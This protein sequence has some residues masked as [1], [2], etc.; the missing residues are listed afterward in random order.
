MHI[1]WPKWLGFGCLL[2]A[3]FLP[4]ISEGLTYSHGLCQTPMVFSCAPSCSA[5]SWDDKRSA[6]LH[7]NSCAVWRS[8][9]REQASKRTLSDVEA[10]GSDEDVAITRRKIRQRKKKQ[11]TT[12]DPVETSSSVSGSL[13]GNHPTQV[14]MAQ[15]FVSI[16]LSVIKFS[17]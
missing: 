6:T 7:R 5:G 12:L 10:S 15:S 3:L 4:N 8:F 13:A 14:S 11:K 2:L 1:S 9:Q 16:K 17:M